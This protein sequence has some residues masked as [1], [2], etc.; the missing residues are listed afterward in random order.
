MIRLEPRSSY[1]Q[2]LLGAVYVDG[3]P[4]IA[5]CVEALYQA[6]VEHDD[7]TPVEALDWFDY[8]MLPLE[9]MAGGPVYV[10]KKWVILD[11]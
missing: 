7:M 3:E 1:D 4:A 6:L 11:E 9:D 2:A 10:Y 8:N 5:Y